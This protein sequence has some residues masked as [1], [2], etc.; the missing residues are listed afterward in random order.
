LT[1]VTSQPEHHEKDPSK[2]EEV[3]NQEKRSEYFPF[4]IPVS[5]NKREGSLYVK[6][7]KA[8]AV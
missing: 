7:A 4:D 5:R 2:S 6:F 3:K 1:R 8:V